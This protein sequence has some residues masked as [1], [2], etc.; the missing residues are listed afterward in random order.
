MSEVKDKQKW[1]VGGVSQ[2]VRAGTRSIDIPQYP[3]EPKKPRSLLLALTA[4]PVAHGCKAI[5]S[6]T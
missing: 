1:P 3:I 5:S 6:E 2:A 4:S